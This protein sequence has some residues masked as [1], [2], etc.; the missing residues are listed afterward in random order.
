MFL[1]ALP[2]VIYNLA[3]PLDTLRSNA[4]MDAAYLPLKAGLLLRTMDGQILFGFMTAADP[5]PQPGLP[6]HWFQS[7][8]LRTAAWTGHPKRNLTLAALLLAVAA[9]PFLW[10]TDGRAP[11]LFGLIAC[12]GTWLPMALTAGAG[13]AAQHT[14]L[15]W[16]FHFL[17][18]AAALARAPLR[19]AVAACAVLCLSNAAVTNQ[20]YADVI[21]NGPAI[22]WTDAIEPLNR[23]LAASKPELVFAADWGF[24]ETLNL[25][26]EGALP[27]SPIDASDQRLNASLF[28]NPHYLFVSHTPEFTYHPEIRS[29]VEAAARQDGYAEDPVATIADRNGRPTFEVFRFRK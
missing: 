6:K 13:W 11:I 1:G 24:V 15:L 18:I 26:S 22:R 5:G 12:A 2:L 10:K 29:A 23:Y 4:R 27:V 17:A 8:S 21:R 3:H 19:W 14:I 25:I 16:P 9:L 28:E 20:Y 7:L